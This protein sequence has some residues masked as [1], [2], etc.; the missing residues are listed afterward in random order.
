MK[1]YILA[2][3]SGTTSVRALIFD[4]NGRI[5][6]CGQHEFTQIFPRA[7]WVEHDSEEIWRMQLA[8]AL[9]AMENCG[10]SASDICAIGITNQR[11]TT[12]V[13]DRA[14]GKPVYNAI[15]WQCRR[16]ADVCNKLKADG[17]ADLICERTGLI[18]DA[19]FSGAKI[20]W[21]L[22]NV[23]GARERAERG[24]LCFGTV[25]SWLIWNL[26]GGRVHVTDVSNASR[27]MLFNIN[28]MEWDKEL[29]SLL[30]VPMSMLPEVKPSS[31]V[32]GECD[33]VLLGAPIPVAGAAGDQQSALFGQCC[34]SEG[35]LKN[36]YGTG[37]FMLMNTGEAPLRS[38]SGLVSTVGW[39]LEGKKPVYALEGSVFVAGAVIQWL[40]DEMK[41]IS[42][43]AES[44]SVAK[45]VPDT[46]GCYFV[47]AFTGMGAPYWDQDARG[48]ITGLTRG[49]GRAHIVRAALE[50]I[51]YQSC[52]VLFAMEKDLGKRIEAVRVDGGAS[53]NNFLMQFQA[54]T[55][56]VE[57]I[58][59][60][61]VETTA[62]GAAFLAGLA[63]GFWKS[64]DELRSLSMGD[65]ARVFSPEA[66]EEKRRAL[67]AGWHQAVRKC[68]G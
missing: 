43:S 63:T 67:L 27:T 24:E 3:D 51:A 44:E 38:K 55:A 62:L 5:R 52:D 19:Y 15:V 59:P 4:K 57:V 29:C 28:T 18:P 49:A 6:G 20:S 61:C 58:R 13:W 35:E 68:R 17:Y 46:N 26:T 7:G 47:P 1:K 60:A 40:R 41:L 53:A 56:G 32:Y 42:S 31:S 36:T 12:I 34:F 66:N 64:E 8:S 30:R 14:T 23:E 21:I 39:C 11:E 45:R 10:C 22:D 37:C 48:I 33:P 9:E 54:D 2:F 16:T 25:D 65:G 50:S